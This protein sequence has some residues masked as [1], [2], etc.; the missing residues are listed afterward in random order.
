M[1]TY[2]A[3]TRANVPTRRAATL[4]GLRK[5]TMDRAKAHDA[6]RATPLV[7]PRPAPANQLSTRE[8]QRLLGVLD[9]EEFIDRAPAQV[10]AALLARGQYLGSESTM[11]RVLRA[12]Q[13]VRERRRQARHPTRARPELTATGPGQVYT[14]DITKLP[15][16][17]RG[18]YFNAYVMIDIYSRYIVG[19]K[20]HSRE[21][22]PLAADMMREV[23]EVHGTPH[24]VHGRPRDVH[25][26]Q[27]RR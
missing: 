1:T 13:Q 14:W 15:G 6:T 9:A 18:D 2:R 19:V 22:A 25:D 17:T 27:N 4:T 8:R 7:H 12:H 24:V 20:V 10:Y 5:S 16:P 3:L 26:L 11:Y 21:S 23:F